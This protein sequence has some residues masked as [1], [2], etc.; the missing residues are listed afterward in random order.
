MKVV[1]I[2][3]TNPNN[4]LTYGFCGY[5]NVKHEEVRRKNK[6]L[7]DRFKE[8]MKIKILYSE[9]DGTQGMLEYIPGKYCWRPVK[10]SGYMFIHCVFVGFK[11][12][13]KGKGYASLMV[14]ECIREAKKQK[15]KGVTVVCRKGPFMAGK[16]FFLK[17]G[18]EVVDRAEPDFELLVKK[19]D[20]NSPE[21][22]FKG[23]WNKRALQYGNGL[24]IIRSDQ[25]PYSVKN[26]QA[27]VETAEKT[28]HIKPRV[29]DLKNCREAQESP[30]PFGSFCILYNGEIISHHPISSTRFGNIMSKILK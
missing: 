12:E 21:P 1:Q 23:N 16:E 30:S 13:Y 14:D 19:F 8:G 28:F 4:I 11:K 18:F 25:C 15:M 7:G 24:I 2:I 17:K 6:W 29:V 26:V 3:D 22:Q 20:P 9:E 10:A 5:K 27:M